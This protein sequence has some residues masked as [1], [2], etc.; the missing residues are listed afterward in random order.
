MQLSEFVKSILR[1]DAGFF[2]VRHRM[3]PPNPVKEYIQEILCIVDKIDSL[4]VNT[5]FFPLPNGKMHKSG[6]KFSI[7][8]KRLTNPKRSFYICF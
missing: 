5:Y 3:F 6:P 4:R 8:I 7:I 2:D 1:M